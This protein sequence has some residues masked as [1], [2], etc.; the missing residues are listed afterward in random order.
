MARRCDRCGGPM[1]PGHVHDC[2]EAARAAKALSE[3]VNE[4]GRCT[5]CQYP[6]DSGG[7]CWRCEPRTG[8]LPLGSELAALTNPEH[9]KLLAAMK[10]QLLIV[11]LKR[12]GGKVDIPIAEVDDTGH[13]N[14][15]MSLRDGV[16][17]F[18]I[19]RN[20]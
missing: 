3:R 5:A 1:G 10:E 15:A 7:R 19:L 20:P 14:L 11:F 8:P 13:D 12:L 4:L 16:F 18:E 17:H 9:A 2:P 6:L